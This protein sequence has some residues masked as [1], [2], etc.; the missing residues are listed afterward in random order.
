MER[1]SVEVLEFCI[2]PEGL[3]E[4]SLARSV[5]NRAK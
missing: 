1:W 3:K 2:V 4:G 5:W